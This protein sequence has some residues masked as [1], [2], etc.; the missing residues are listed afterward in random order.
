MGFI[1]F[2][3]LALSKHESQGYAF[4][5]L[6][7]RCF[8]WFVGWFK[9][10]NYIGVTCNAVLNTHYS[11]SPPFKYKCNC[12]RNHHADIRGKNKIDMKSFQYQMFC[13]KGK[14]SH[15]LF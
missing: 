11:P 14:Y 7:L 5:H 4:I 8:G 6:Y 10:A 13:D 3:F 12:P 2:F 9:F 1:S 15:S